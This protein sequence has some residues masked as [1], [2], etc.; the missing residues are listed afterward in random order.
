MKIFF[1][2]ISNSK[3]GQRN[4]KTALSV[5]ICILLFELTGNE[6]SASY[7]CIAAIMSVQETIERSVDTGTHRISGTFVGAILGVLFIFLGNCFDLQMIS[8]SIL[9]SVVIILII[10]FY[11]A[12]EKQDSIAICCMVFIVIALNYV[13]NESAYLYALERTIDTLIGVIVA[14]LINRYFDIHKIFKDK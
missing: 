8:K 5:F 6:S 10:F 12:F 9:I 14:L 4:I 1:E 3:I 2:K 7:A 11:N 13:N